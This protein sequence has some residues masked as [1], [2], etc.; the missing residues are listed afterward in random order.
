M[1]TAIAASAPPAAAFV[2]I[3]RKRGLQLPASDAVGLRKYCCY[4]EEDEH[5]LKRFLDSFDFFLPL[6]Q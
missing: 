2:C 6:I 1:Y 5:S 3:C 4:H